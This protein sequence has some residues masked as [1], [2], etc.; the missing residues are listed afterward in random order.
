MSKIKVLP[1]EIAELIAAGEVVE[2]PASV[3]KE[4]MENAIDAG[5]SSVT[6]EIKNGGITYIRVT[7]NGCGISREDIRNAFISHATSKISTR[8][9]LY[10]IGTLGFRGEALASIAAVSNVEVLTRT[11]EEETGTR[12]CISAGEETLVDDAGCPLGTTIVVRDLFFNTPARMK[13]LKKDV[14]E[15]NAVAGIVD[16]IALS[17]PDVSIRFIREGKS[18]LFT[19]GS[20]DLK[21]AAYEIFGK[22]FADGLIEADYSFESVKISGLVSKPTKS[23][24]NRNMQFFFVNGRLVKSGTAS[25]ALS[26][27]YKN[28]I[29]VGKFPYCVL[30]ITT[31]PGLVDVNVHPAKIEVRFANERTVFSAVY[32]AAKNALEHR[33]EAPKVTIPRTAQTELFEP[34]RPKTEQM[35]LPEKQPDFWNRMSS[36]EYR[37]AQQPERPT[38][39]QSAAREDIITVASPDKKPETADSE[40][41]TIQHFLDA[42]RAK[43]EETAAIEADIRPELSEKAA[44]LPDE[45]PEETARALDTAVDEKPAELPVTVIGEAFKTYI[46][47]QQGESIFLVDKH[48]AHERMLFNELVKNDSK[49]ST[50]MLLT[51]ITVTLSKEEY[52]SVLDNLDML[53]QAG[54]AVE[55]FGYSVVIV[56]ECPME[57]SADEVADVVAELAG[58]LVENR[59]KLISEKKEWLFSLMACKAAIKGGMYTTE[60]ER[61][62]FIKRLFASPEIRYCP[63]GRPVMIEIT[64]RELEKNFGR[65]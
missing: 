15:A 49:R 27:A 17:N 33:D 40:P 65:V 7:D 42:Q 53:M 41:S 30:N 35:R 50:Q 5:S 43:K 8:D 61:E 64:R 18:A 44:T 60:Y 34:V 22:D 12:Y 16:K 19:S 47:V 56:R 36:S 29:M 52:S 4:L 23:R 3:I 20:G 57:I 6:V 1:K 63:H 51:P 37:S 25:A 39:Q 9:D 62:L 38:Y 48:A 31:A 59:Q 28:S 58:Y 10:A 24:P 14:S 2:R 21:T 26:E 54:F 45:K 55:D 46:I 13:F 32:Y 11:T